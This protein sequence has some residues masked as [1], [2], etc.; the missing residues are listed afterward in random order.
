[1][2]IRVRAN[3]GRNGLGV[4]RGMLLIIR[5]SGCPICGGDPLL[6][7]GDLAMCGN[8]ECF[9]L[10]WNYTK[11]LDENLTETKFVNLDTDKE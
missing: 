1:M 4:K 2:G 7:V 3:R 10:F 8:M 11:T 6:I 9:A 5:C